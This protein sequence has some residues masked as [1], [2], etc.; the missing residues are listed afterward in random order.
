M[1]K[2]ALKIREREWV[3]S[4]GVGEDPDSDRELLYVELKK[5][6]TFVLAPDGESSRAFKSA[7]DADK[8]T[9]G[10]YVIYKD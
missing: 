10:S 4:A 1:N 7:R 5:G 2:T 8:Q 9:R 6:W 3:E